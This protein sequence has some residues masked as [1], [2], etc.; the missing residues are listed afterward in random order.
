M[1]EA[2]AAKRISEYPEPG[3]ERRRCCAVAVAVAVAAAAS[4]VVI[5]GVVAAV[6][7]GG[8]VHHSASHRWPDPASHSGVNGMANCAP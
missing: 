3:P 7:G 4:A 6:V 8:V 1:T 2:D 5:A